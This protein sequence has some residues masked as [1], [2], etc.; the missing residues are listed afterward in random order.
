MGL[1]DGLFRRRKPPGASQ[2]WEEAVPEPIPESPALLVGN[3]QGIGDREDQQDSFAVVNASNP[4]RLR[5][6]GLLAVVADGMGGLCNGKQASQ[7]AVD[8]MLACLGQLDGAVRVPEWLYRVV[9]DASEQVYR[10][11]AGQSGTTLVAVHVKEGLLHWLSV[12]DSGI[13]LMRSGGVF[14]LNREHTYLNRL[15]EHELF[16]ERVIDKQH[17][18]GDEDARRLT[19]FVGIDHLQEV[20]LNLRPLRLMRGDVILLCSDGISGI[21]SPPELMEAMSLP[22]DEG[23]ALLETLVMEKRVQGQDNYTGIMISYP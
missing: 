11:F 5:K 6:E 17:A 16:E 20:D 8:R 19:S 22:P 9:F 3:I 1:F 7:S 21:L 4:E 10:Q 23:C 13:Y 2:A 18:E 14:Q 15:Y 12:G